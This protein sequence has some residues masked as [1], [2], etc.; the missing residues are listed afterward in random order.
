MSSYGIFELYRRQAV[1]LPLQRQPASHPDCRGGG[2]EWVLER[3]AVEN[4]RFA[5]LS[6]EGRMPTAE[7]AAALVAA[8]DNIKCRNF[9]AQKNPRV[10]KRRKCLRLVVT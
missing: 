3:C 7:E 6:R 10:C 8:I 5:E 2:A 1:A 4:K 9:A